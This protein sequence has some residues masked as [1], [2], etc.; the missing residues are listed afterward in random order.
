MPEAIEEQRAQ[1]PVSM[2]AS[3]Q[4]KLPIRADGPILTHPGPK[5]LATLVL[6][7]FARSRPWSF[8]PL[9]RYDIFR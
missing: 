8:L 9:T 1:T 6:R 4:H 3:T 2:E 7:G 5:V